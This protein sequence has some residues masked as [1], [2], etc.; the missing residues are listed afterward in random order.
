VAPAPAPAALGPTG[1]DVTTFHRLCERLAT[2]AGVLPTRPAPIP[3]A[4]WDD[5]L[6][7]AAEAAIDALP[8]A[9]YHAIVVDE[10][11]DFE[12][13]WFELLERLLID[14][15]DIFW[16]FHDPGQALIQP[17]VVAGLGFERLELFEN[18]RNPGSIAELAARFYRGGEEPTAFRETER[19][20]TVIGA[21]PG[22]AT[23]EALRKTLHRLIEEERVPPFRIAVLSGASAAASEVWRHRRFGNACLE[24]AAI[25]DDGS[26]RGLAPED[27]PDEPDEVLFESIRRF[28]G[29]ERE[30][31]VLVE[32]PTDGDR[33]DELLYVGLTRATTELVVIAPPE[34]VERLG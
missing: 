12:A 15:D 8:H 27:V 29:M 19:R 9:R 34:L 21:E 32:L 16:V 2:E 5:T 14:P 11:Q 7:A 20:H 18:H 3:R 28:K 23:L 1:L 6:P 26:S 31:V 33:L 4:W 25:F 24:N 17:D 30:V 10:G 22:A 13:R